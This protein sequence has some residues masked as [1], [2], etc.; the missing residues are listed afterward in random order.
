MCIPMFDTF[1]RGGVSSTAAGT[2]TAGAAAA[3]GAAA[4]AEAAAVAD[5]EAACPTGG[6]AGAATSSRAE[7]G[8]GVVALPSAG[9]WGVD[10]PQATAPVRVRA[11]ATWRK[12]EDNS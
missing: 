7:G 10:E 2:E 1:P 5:G 3:I 8:G 4:E 11:I 9:A 12:T 6:V